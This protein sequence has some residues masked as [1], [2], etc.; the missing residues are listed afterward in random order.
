MNTDL[1]P[2]PSVILPAVAI[3]L[4][5]RLDA[6]LLGPYFA[7]SELIPG[8]GGDIIVSDKTTRAALIRRLVYPFLIGAVIAAL[9]VS[10][11]SLA[12]VG[13][14]GAGL[15]LWPIIFH[16]LPHGI[17][18]RSR[19]LWVLYLSLLISYAGLSL[20][21][22]Y[23]VELMREAGSGDIGKYISEHF[24]DWAITAAV[25]LIFSTWGRG[26]QNALNRRSRSGTDE[27]HE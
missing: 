19:M 14:L 13:F 16:G 25:V 26:A 18:R 22:G 6:K 1:V 21:G 10:G 27:R 12:S 23:V 20:L 9:G 5:V 8:F 2:W 7:L 11:L 15:L 4:A 3:A 24:R 17:S